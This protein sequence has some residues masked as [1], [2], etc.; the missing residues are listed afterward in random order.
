MK[1]WHC[2]PFREGRRGS[3]AMF[4][5]Q[6]LQCKGCSG[7][8][9]SFPVSL[10]MQGLQWYPTFLSCK[11][12]NG[13]SMQGLQWYP[14]FLFCKVCNGTSMLG[15]HCKVCNATLLPS[16]K[17]L[18]CQSFMYYIKFKIL[19]NCTIISRIFITIYSKL[20]CSMTE[21]PVYL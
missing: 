7:T 6:C 8:P 3:I 13:T 17:G 19:H 18:Q 21:F 20:A 1:L 9:P 12:C 14:T 16:L 4:A 5:M 11:V 15:L 2:N 10:A